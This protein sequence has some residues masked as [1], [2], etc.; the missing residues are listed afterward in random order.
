[1]THDFPLMGI[2]C[3]KLLTLPKHLQNALHDRL[4]EKKHS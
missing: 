3:I 1:M 2:L 4:C